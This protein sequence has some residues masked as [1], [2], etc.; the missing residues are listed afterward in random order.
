MCAV[1]VSASRPAEAGER[2]RIYG[3]ITDE[4]GEPLPGAAVAVQ[5][6]KGVGAA[7]GKDGTYEFYYTPAGQ[8]AVVLEASVMGYET[9][10]LRLREPSGEIKADFVLK[11]SQEQIE[12]VVVTATRTP[13][14]LKDVPVITRVITAQDISHSD[15]IHIGE[16]LEVELPGIEF[17]YSMDQQVSLNM[18]GFGGNSIL[19]LVDGERLAGET[20]DNIDYNRLNLDNVERVEIVK[21]AASSLYGSNA[22]GGVVNIITKE[23]AEPWSVNLNGRYGSE[24]EMVGSASVG[25][26]AKRLSSLTNVQYVSNDPV[27]LPSDGDYTTV[28]GGHNYNIKEQLV[29]RPIDNLKLTGKAGYYFR[30]RD[31]SEEL[32]DR[33]RDFNG[34]LKAEYSPGGKDNITV[35]YIFDQYD[36]SDFAPAT[37]L[38]IREYS[39]V[40][41]TVRALYTHSFND[42][43]NVVVGG[44][45]MRDYLMSYQFQDGAKIQYNWDLFVQGDW[46]PT[47]RLNLVGGVR[48]DYFSDQSLSN[49]SPKLGVMYKLGPVSLRGSYAGGFRAPTLKEM[50]MSFNMANIFMIYGNEELE[51]ERSH[52]FS[53]SGEYGTR[54]YNATLTGFYNIID[55]NIT[56]AWSEALGGMLYVN[57]SPMQVYGADVNLSA[58]YDFGLKLRLSYT[59][60]HEHIDEGEPMT[61]STRPHSATVKIEYGKD[62]KKYG[63][64]A[65]LTG[66]VMSAV[67][68]D[69]YTS[70]TDY[71]QTEEETSPGYTI[72][73]LSLSQRIWRGMRL[74]IIIDNLFNYIPEYYYSNTP[75][76][77]GTTC[78][79]GMSLNLHEIIKN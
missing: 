12:T 56:T 11:E 51:P 72:W 4:S 36:K 57:M 23:P 67:T 14:L 10:Y 33:Y 30:Q 73:K 29:Y 70:Y 27:Y 7:A 5:G 21:G 8:K 18:Q 32:R 44:D 1:T 22:V 20:L 78:S 76:T 60:T 19:F 71:S 59:Y 52:N 68:Y 54:R 9:E 45:F 79:V 35:S 40:Q 58:N 74:N 69:V 62:W 39:N 63:F 25:L 77:I 15:A 3:T 49:V 17:S 6:V 47:P 53:L 38:D 43:D 50:Y 26:K 75:A 2:L 42:K 37:A 61:S 34:A 46:N 65:A 16:L 13:K 24:G 28:Y 41:H 31:A 48:F 66:R 64:D 55:N